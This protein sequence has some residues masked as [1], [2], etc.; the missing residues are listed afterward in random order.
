MQLLQQLQITHHGAIDGFTCSCHRLT[1]PGGDAV[2]VDCG[3]FQG[4]ETSGDGASAGR[5]EISFPI[6]TLRAL[7]VTGGVE[8]MAAIARTAS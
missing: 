3:L 6:D 4:A 7:L 2:L 8:G 5:L 1:A